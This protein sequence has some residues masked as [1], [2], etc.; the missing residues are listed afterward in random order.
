MDTLVF[1]GHEAPHLHDRR[2]PLVRSLVQ[3]RSLSRG[4]SGL[5]SSRIDLLPHQVEVVRRVLEDPIQRY[6]LADEVGLGK[7]VEA[8]VVLRQFLLDSETGS[9]VVVVPPLLVDQWSEE[10]EDKFQ[11]S[12]FAPGR[13]SVISHDDVG[14]DTLR[15]N[16]DFVIIDEAH[17][18]AALAAASSPECG[19]RFA[20]F[21]RLCSS[22]DS[23]LLLSA[24]PALNNERNFLA[25]LHLLDPII[26]SIDDVDGFCAKVRNRQEVGQLLLTLQEGSPSFAVKAAIRRLREYFP[27]DALLGQLCDDLHALDVSAPDGNARDIAIRS[28]R[29]HMSETYRLHRRMLRNRRE[30]I[31]VSTL[32]GRATSQSESPRTLLYDL[33]ER[34]PRLHELLEEWRDTAAATVITNQGTSIGPTTEEELTTVFRVLY[35]ALGTWP[36]A[37]KAI[38]EARLDPSRHS[39]DAA[40]FAGSDYE[41]LRRA[42]MFDGEREILDGILA[43]LSAPAEQGDRIALL[44][45]SLDEYSRSGATGGIPPKCVVFTSHPFVCSEIVRQLH[46]AFG[47]NVVSCYRSGMSRRDVEVELEWFRTERKCFVLICDRAGEEGRNLQ[48]ADRVIHFD[49]PL[50][51]NRMEQRI[52]RLDRIGRHSAITSTIFLGSECENSLFE[53]WYR[54]LDQGFQVFDRSIASLQFFVEKQMPALIQSLFRHGAPGL[55]AAIPAIHEGIANEQQRSSEQDALDA[56]DASEQSA[57]A[58]YD[59]IQELEA[60]HLEMEAAVQ[61]WVGDALNFIRDQNVYGSERTVRYRPAVDRDGQL[62]TLVP[63]YW[64]R[65]YFAP[66]I[67]THGAFN[68]DTALRI[69]GTPVFRIGEGFIDEM[70]RHLRWDDRGQAFA[71]WRHEPNWDPTDGAEWVGFRF[72]YVVS[73]DLQEAKQVLKKGQGLSPSAIRALT[74]RA[75]TLFPPLVEVV[76]VSTDGVLITDA[77]LLAVLERPYFAYGS[78]GTDFNLANEGLEAIEEV[79]PTELWEST[80]RT[81]RELSAKEAMNRG[82]PPLRDRCAALAAQAEREL[83]TRLAQ[84]RVRLAGQ[85]AGSRAL[86]AFEI[87]AALNA[88]LV[89]GIRNPELNLDSVGFIVISGRPPARGAKS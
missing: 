68:R 86:D 3:Q 12:R 56:V 74:R 63:S 38:V 58:C 24:T 11:V 85:A 55:V 34:V 40:S 70:I 32:A 4:M 7:T 8:G 67:R 30:G 23:V 22:A 52:G 61:G 69:P 84:L 29:V 6:L 14:A 33:D 37:F 82:I 54:V 2:F 42:P 36:G 60:G 5:L 71:L 89:S 35:L 13:V 59:S 53:S 17:H 66:H 50:A 9:A 43:I 45:Q 51:P 64:I 31:E 62:R 65:K 16:L 1:K 21:E 41:S 80:C 88:S 39:P 78:G 28:V 46:S 76:Y 48:F 18:I 75:D 77:E 19:H 26:Y 49:I 47:D 83:S 20:I 27:A 25:M 57:V 15:D 81:A 87:E 10:L 79:V 73:A 44:R 72:N